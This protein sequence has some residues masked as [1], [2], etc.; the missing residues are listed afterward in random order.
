MDLSGGDA[1]FYAHLF[2]WRPTGDALFTVDGQVVAGR[3]PLRRPGWHVHVVAGDV[4]AACRSVERHGGEVVTAPDRSALGT[5]AMVAD[6]AGATFVIREPGTRAE[7]SQRPGAFSWA[8]LCT[9]DPGSAKSFYRAVFGWDAVGVPLRTPAGEVDYTVF[10]AGGAEV[11]GVLPAEGAFWPAGV[12]Y[13]LAYVEVRDTGATAVRVAELGG[14]VLVEPV[15]VP[16]IGRIGV[17]AGRGGEL[18]GAIQLPDQPS[19][20]V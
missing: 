5:L 3:C 1:T 15:E 6:P 18:F 9:P 20:S 19:T 12:P 10:V 13:W 7:V 17:F 11:A 16:R 4:P 8:E 14:E 2:G